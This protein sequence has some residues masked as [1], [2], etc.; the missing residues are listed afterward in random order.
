MR[1]NANIKYIEVEDFSVSKEKFELYMDENYQLLKTE[2]FPELDKLGSYYESPNYISHTDSKKT[3]FDKV[4]QAV[5][6]KA[7]QSK[8]KI[9]EDINIT[10][11]V[12]LDIGCGTGEFLVEG[13]NRGWNVLGYEPNEGARK[14]SIEKGISIVN[15]LSEVEDHSV[16]VITMWHVLEHVVD[17]DEQISTLKRILKKG[18]TLI[19][20]VPNYNSYDAKYYGKYWAA[21]DVPRHLWH[22]SQ[23]SIPLLFNPYGFELVEKYPMLFDSFY[24]SL[25]SE[26]Y[27]TGKKNWFKAFRVGLKSNIEARTNLEYSSLI[28]YLKKN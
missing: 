27:K 20:A 18:G 23:M 16:N 17:L 25:L 11:G 2:P 1:I 12:L 24:V 10:K 21:Y 14:L 9:L 8:Y 13:N 15:E 22:F 5:K 4:Y 28:Y 26:Q 7:I 6:S 3:F 19:I